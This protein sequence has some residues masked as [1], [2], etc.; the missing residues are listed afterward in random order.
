MLDNPKIGKVTG[1]ML[2]ADMQETNERRFSKKHINGYI[3]TAIRQVPESESRVHHGVE[4]LKYWLDQEYYKEKVVRLEQIRELDLEQLVRD[5]FVGIAYT[6]KEELFVSVT[7]MLAG[8]LGFD[9][10]RDAIL[11]LAEIVTVLSHTGAF[12]LTKRS[13]E[14]QLMIK[15]Q[16]PLPLELIDTMSRA[17]YLPPMVCEPQ[18]LETNF[19]SPYLTHNDCLILGKGNAHSDDI[20]LDVIN[21]QNNVAMKLDTDFLSTVE[22]MPNPEKPLRSMD[23]IKNW[24][25][26]KQTSYALYELLTKQG[27][28]F[29]IT[30]KVD[31][32]GRLYA[33]GYHITSQGTPFKKAMLELYNEEIVDGVPS[34]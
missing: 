13:Q 12:I 23:D 10:K 32:R 25:L 5:I 16:I 9:E 8:K 28:K 2:P 6:F 17:L 1:Q 15:S 24:N 21:T 19:E 30:N 27:N 11:T 22:E 31:K 20:C 33:Q 34:C 7:S 3:D 26:F 4:I 29:W 14:S 18:Q